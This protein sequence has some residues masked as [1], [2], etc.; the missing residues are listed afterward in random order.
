MPGTPSKEQ[1]TAPL[2]SADSS[3]ITAPTFNLAQLILWNGE[4]AS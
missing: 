2:I 1:T 3:P 4:K